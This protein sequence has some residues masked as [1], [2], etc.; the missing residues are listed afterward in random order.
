MRIF[1]GHGAAQLRRKPQEEI[2]RIFC[3][4]IAFPLKP[5]RT[6]TSNKDIT[7]CRRNCCIDV[8]S[9]HGTACATNHPL[10]ATEFSLIDQGIYFE[11]RSNKEYSC[12]FN[13]S[14]LRVEEK[15]RGM[16]NWE[17]GRGRER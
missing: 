11:A 14:F 7:L 8:D 1:P 15:E 16:G 12:S 3:N 13:Y 17:R 6:G 2:L 9:I 4:Q 5:E 10:S